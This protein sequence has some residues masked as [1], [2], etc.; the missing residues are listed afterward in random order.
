MEFE[1]KMIRD[2]Y[3]YYCFNCGE[4]IAYEE[5]IYFIGRVILCKYCAE[6]DPMLKILSSR[7]YMIQNDLKLIKYSLKYNKNSKKKNSRLFMW[8]FVGEFEIISTFRISKY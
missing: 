4:Y 6:H 2:P 7:R 8:D 5:P 3:P 1:T